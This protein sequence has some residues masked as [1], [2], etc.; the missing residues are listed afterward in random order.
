MVYLQFLN[1][2]QKDPDRVLEDII[3]D[4][5]SNRMWE[6][7]TDKKEWEAFFNALY[8]VSNAIKRKTTRLEDELKDSQKKFAYEQSEKDELKQLYQQEREKAEKLIAANDN[9]EREGQERFQLERLVT[10]LKEKVNNYANYL[11]E[12]DK[13]IAELKP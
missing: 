2:E 11:N 6:S 1:E 5:V 12:A 7:Y 3:R 9:L 13:K 10:T 4:I 8:N